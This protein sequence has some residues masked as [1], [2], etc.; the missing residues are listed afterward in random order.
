MQW[1]FATYGEQDV[2]VKHGCPRRQQSPNMAKISMSYIL[3]PPHPQGHAMSMNCEQSLDELIVQVWLL[4][5]N[6]NF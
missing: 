5:H 1:Y 6:P 4:Y 2:F 3:T